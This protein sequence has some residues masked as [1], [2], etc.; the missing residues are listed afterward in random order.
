MRIGIP[1]ERLAN[2]A[3]VAATPKTVEQ[4]LKLGFTVAIENGA[5][6]LASFD[7]AAFQQ[8]GAEIV[9]YEDIWQ[10]DVILKVNAPEDEEIALMNPGSTLISFIWPAQTKIYYKIGRASGYRHGDGFRAAY[11]SRPIPRRPELHGK[12]RGL[13]CHC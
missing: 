12:H 8:A 10:S 3:R 5:G 11:F 6:K 13:S 9:G 7:D 1:R 4:L 2:E